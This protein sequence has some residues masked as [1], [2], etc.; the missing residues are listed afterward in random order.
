M[1]VAHRDVDVGLCY[2]HPALTETRDAPG[3]DVA[4]VVRRPH[5]STP[6]A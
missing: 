1:P 5:T 6:M 4:Y 2:R 3:E